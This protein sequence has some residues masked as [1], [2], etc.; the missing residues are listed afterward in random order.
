MVRYLPGVILIAMIIPFVIS[1][2][3]L[4][5]HHSI[6]L[7]AVMIWGFTPCYLRLGRI[8]VL[9]FLLRGTL[10]ESSLSELT[11]SDLEVASLLISYISLFLLPLVSM[12][13]RLSHHSSWG[14]EQY[15]PYLS[16]N[17]SCMGVLR[18]S[19]VAT[20]IMSSLN[21]LARTA[22]S[23]DSNPYPFFKGGGAYLDRLCISQAQ[24]V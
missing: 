8:P 16:S 2:S 10:I 14:M 18:L 22:Q 3:W 6:M 12:V 15:S 1:H 4:F 5:A 24:S 13:N 17:S 19:L 9:A 23:S 7:C 21:Y 20:R 11:G